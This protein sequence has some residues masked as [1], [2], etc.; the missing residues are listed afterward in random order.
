MRY[1]GAD[2]RLLRS[3]FAERFTEVRSCNPGYCERTLGYAA[4]CPSGGRYLRQRFPAARER[5]STKKIGEFKISLYATAD[6]LRGHPIPA[7]VKDLDERMERDISKKSIA[8]F[9]GMRT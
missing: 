2:K 7:T 5:L 3:R 4:R 9:A 8:I 1:P 6:Y